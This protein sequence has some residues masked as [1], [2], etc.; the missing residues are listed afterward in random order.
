MY[1]KYNIN[2]WK[3]G[4]D[5][6]KKVKQPLEKEDISKMERRVIAKNVLSGKIAKGLYNR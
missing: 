6:E 3:S 4:K 5:K 2:V 1:Y